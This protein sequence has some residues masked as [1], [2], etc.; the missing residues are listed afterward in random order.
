[1]GLFSL[2]S[3]GLILDPVQRLVIA[4]PFPKFFNFNEGGVALPDEPFTV[5]EKLDGS[6]GILFHH[7]GKWR[8]TTRGRLE[9]PARR[10]GDGASAWP[11]RSLAPG[12]GND[13]SGRDCL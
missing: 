11:R 10:L 9:Q 4:T 6:L 2:I 3:R 13:L 8:I 1:M 12:A 5:S 7:Q